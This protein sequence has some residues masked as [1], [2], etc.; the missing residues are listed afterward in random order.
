MGAYGRA[1]E[2]E[3][4][5]RLANFRR[6]C[7]SEE[8]AADIWIDGDRYEIYPTVDGTAVALVQVSVGSNEAPADLTFFYVENAYAAALRHLADKVEAIDKK[9]R[10]DGV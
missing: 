4:A 9:Y 10:E 8:R 2:A 7:D 6:L 3:L 5:A 1:Y